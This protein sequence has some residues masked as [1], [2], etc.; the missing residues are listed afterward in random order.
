MVLAARY[1]R[2]VMVQK[3]AAGTEITIGVLAT[4]EIQML[5]TLE[6]VSDNPAYALRIVP[7]VETEVIGR[8][9]WLSR[10]LL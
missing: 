1:D 5:P 9:V 3:F 2:R 4:P 7:V 10:A 6:I 8:V